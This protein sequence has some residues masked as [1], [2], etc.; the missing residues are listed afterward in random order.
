MAIRPILASLKRH[1]IPVALLVIEIALTCFIALNATF[2]M[3]QLV[4]RTHTH[5]G[6]AED[7]LVVLQTAQRV[8][9]SQASRV[10]TAVAALKAVPGVESV[11]VTNQY[12]Y[13][14]SRTSS[15]IRLT[16]QQNK[17]TLAAATYYGAHLVDTFGLRL[18]AGRDFKPAEYVDSDVVLNGGRAP[19]VV[20]ITRSLAKQ[21]WPHGGALG[22]TFYVG[23][24]VRVVG[25]VAHLLQ[26]A[27]LVGPHAQYSML[28]PV[29]VTSSGGSFVL[30]TAP[31]RRADV[32]EAAT[33]TLRKLH[34]KAIFTTRATLAQERDDMFQRVQSLLR[35]MLVVILALLLVTALGI[36]GL[37][38]FWVAQ[39]RKQIGVRRALG[40][41]RGDILRYFQIEN[42]LIVTLGIVVGLV[43]A[44]GLSLVLMLEAHMP[45]LPWAY[46]PAAAVILWLLGQLAVLGPAL[47][48]ANVPPVV[49]TRS[50]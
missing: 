20:I 13:G 42:F 35:V 8:G 34:P 10:Q 48:A 15:G 32:L 5:S 27:S 29:R 30:R 3:S 14:G 33:A 18:V 16:Q 21:L 36:V 9:D 39:R 41:T 24:P 43:L 40:A 12:P 4:Q 22:K 46:L 45:H 28:L 47:R 19:A 23:F 25:I 31:Q 44:V 17:V 49:A 50:V 2:V 6:V 26:P 7:Q 11:T 38:S 37:A 1:K